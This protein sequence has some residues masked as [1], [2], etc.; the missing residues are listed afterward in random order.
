M[1]LQMYDL[2][3]MRSVNLIF[4]PSTLILLRPISR[5]EA[6][7]VSRLSILNARIALNAP[8]L[9]ILFLS[10]SSKSSLKFND[11]V[12]YWDPFYKTNFTSDFSMFCFCLGTL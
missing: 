6:A 11:M 4:T 1:I 8:K 9:A 10:N 7:S 5:A 2:Y 3:A 12:I